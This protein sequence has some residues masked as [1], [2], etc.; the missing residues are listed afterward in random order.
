MKNYCLIIFMFFLSVNTWS[1]IVPESDLNQAFNQAKSTRKDVLVYVIYPDCRQNPNCGGHRWLDSLFNKPEITKVFNQNFIVYELN[2]ESEKPEEKVLL[3]TIRYLYHSSLY[4][5]SPDKERFAQFEI[6]TMLP[7][8]GLGLVIRDTVAAYRAMI[9]KR[10]TLKQK[11]ASGQGSLEEVEYLM[12]L[13]N[14]IGIIDPDLYDHYLLQNGGLDKEL[15]NEI[16]GCECIKMDSP[17]FQTLIKAKDYIGRYFFHALAYEQVMY[18]TWDLDSARFERALR[19]FVR[20][21]FSVLDGKGGVA[22]LNPHKAERADEILRFR[23]NFAHTAENIK[24]IDF[25]S[26]K[27]I[28]LLQKSYK[29]RKKDYV[30]RL[31]RFVDKPRKSGSGDPKVAQMKRKIQN[32]KDFDHQE[33]SIYNAIAWEIVQNVQDKSILQKALT[34]SK[35]SLGWKRTPDLLDTYARLLFALGRK[36]EAIQHQKEAIELL[37]GKYEEFKIPD[38]QRTLDKFLKG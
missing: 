32:E 35:M 4:F 37:R 31:E 18:A 17:F 33:G 20:T 22:L 29:K 24:D 19:Y 12:Q 7:D 13:N 30:S 11:I 34:W 26:E 5:F 9:P 16:R 21:K 38:F 2:G 15:L 1:Q 25:Y 3:S 36:T 14:R 8:P 23:L 27:R 6:Q 10:K 28:Q